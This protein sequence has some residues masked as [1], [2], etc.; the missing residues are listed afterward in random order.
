[1]RTARATE[2]RGAQPAPPRE[3]RDRRPRRVH[4]LGVPGSGQRTGTRIAGGR[5]CP[6]PAWRARPW[7]RTSPNLVARAPWGG[8]PVTCAAIKERSMVSLSPRLWLPPALE[9]SM[10]QLPLRVSSLH[11]WR[12]SGG[13]A[14]VQSPHGALGCLWASG[15]RQLLGGGPRGRGRAGRG[16]GD[17]APLH[18][19][20]P[21]PTPGAGSVRNPKRSQ[22]PPFVRGMGKLRPEAA[23]LVGAKT[24]LEPKS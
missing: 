13:A 1:M 12:V 15:S 4:Q 18:V 14:S 16:S 23:P 24:S 22:S 19:T 21:G 5:H 3:S 8:P 11:S 9:S 20:T 7:P 2:V 17:W 6:V 10:L